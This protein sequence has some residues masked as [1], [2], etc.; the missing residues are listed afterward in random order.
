M[1]LPILFR[2]PFPA[3]ATGSPSWRVLVWVL[4]G[5][6]CVVAAA[7]WF[8]RAP[9]RQAP[10][11]PAPAGGQDPDR[12]APD[13]YRGA[14]TVLV[15]D[16][17]EPLRAMAVRTLETMGFHTV[18]ARDG[19]EALQ[20][21]QAHQSGIRLMLLDLTMPRMGG[22]EAYRV[23]RRSGALVP[24]ILTSGFTELDVLLHFRGKGIAGFLQKPYLPEAL[25]AK[26]SRALEHPDAA[27]VL[28][29]RPPLAWSREMETGNPILDF[30]HRELT[31][32][33]NHLVAS[34]GLLGPSLEQE[35]AFTQ[36]ME[37]ALAHFAVEDALMERVGYPQRRSHGKIHET[38]IAQ[39]K[40]L[41]RRIRSGEQGITQPVLDFLECWLVHHMQEE[42][43]PLAKFLKGEGH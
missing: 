7:W 31:A 18:E 11:G 13:T 38:L 41:A 12:C 26:V 10:S 15:A 8:R 23:L 37:H 27:P 3:L 20:V 34:T 43:L 21:F 30:Q 19:L 6:A 16:D 17:E 2:T 36:F 32:T 29:L 24:V 22:E 9:R 28:C 25:V 4:L 1:L 40:D 35:Q 42:D 14:G 5:A 33:F 39:A